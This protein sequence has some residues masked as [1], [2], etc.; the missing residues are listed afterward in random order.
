MKKKILFSFIILT[1]FLFH[2]LF[3]L[4]DA[5]KNYF[6]G[7]FYKS[8]E[9]YFL[10][11]TEKM[12]DSRFKKTVILM[13]DNDENSSW[14][15]VINKS[16]GSI[17]LGQLIDTSLDISDE[18]KELYE[19]SIPIFWGGPVDE[20]SIFILHTKDYTGETTINYNGFSITR[21]YQILFDIA[22]KKGP[23]KSLVILGYSGWGAGQLEGEMDQ[24]G[25]ILSEAD[26]DIIFDKGVIK[27]WLKA[28]KRS[29]IRL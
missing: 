20:T 24:G 5:P 7:K 12:R 1:I 16:I 28:Y 3:V 8:I 26:V 11:A 18:K 21:D 2:D 17:P 22:L 4:A 23:K 13:L 27:K 9:N 29:F 15:I 10:V 19:E 25:W 6:K 14:G